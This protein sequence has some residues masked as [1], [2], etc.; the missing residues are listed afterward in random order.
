MEP[1]TGFIAPEPTPGLPVLARFLAP[2]PANIAA[3]YVS[4]YSQTDELVVNPFCRTPVLALEAE[5]LGRRALLADAEAES[6]LR[7]CLQRTPGSQSVEQK[8]S[9][10]R[11][12]GR[13][14]A[15]AAAAEDDCTIAR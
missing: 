2:L 15:G 11:C 7:W 8:A 6:H 4:A 9:R 1:I 3:A 14:T 12:P 13:S 5:R 10:G